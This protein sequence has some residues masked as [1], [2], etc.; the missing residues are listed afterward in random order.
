MKLAAERYLLPEDVD[1]LVRRGGA[2]W[3]WAMSQPA[4]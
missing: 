4:P 2:E 1:G 3:G